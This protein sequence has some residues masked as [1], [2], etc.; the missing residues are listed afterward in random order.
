MPDD[1]QKASLVS[2]KSAALTLTGLLLGGAGVTLPQALGHTPQ[3]LIT[4]GK[5]SA[6]LELYV[7]RAADVAI[8][9]HTKGTHPGVVGKEEFNELKDQVDATLRLTRKLCRVQLPGD[10]DCDNL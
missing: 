1:T 7:E 9:H 6:D 10:E 4:N 3:V 2:W 8:A 5:P